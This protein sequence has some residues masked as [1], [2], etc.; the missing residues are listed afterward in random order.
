MGAFLACPNRLDASDVDGLLV[1]CS[2]GV[3]ED[4]SVKLYC[5][6]QVGPSGG[7][8]MTCRGFGCLVREKGLVKRQGS[9][10]RREMTQATEQVTVM[11][12]TGFH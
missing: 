5:Q 11:A 8:Q 2:M 7:M 10:H 1:P 4:V 9:I 12:Q 3:F 6:R